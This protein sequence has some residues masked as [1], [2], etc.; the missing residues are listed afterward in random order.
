MDKAG[1]WLE[2]GDRV[3]VV[4]GIEGIIERVMFC[5]GSEWPLYRVEY[6]HAAE[7][8]FCEVHHPDVRK[9]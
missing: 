7:L 8:R 6:W 9:L 2:P 1:K 4:E 5:R 3:V